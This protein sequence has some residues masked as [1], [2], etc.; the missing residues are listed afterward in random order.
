MANAGA[1]GPAVGEGLEI[2]TREVRLEAQKTDR[3]QQRET[4]MSS[5]LK[6]WETAKK[7]F[8]GKV[9]LALKSA[10]TGCPAETK[11]ELATLLKS[12]TGL[13][14][15]LRAVDLAFTLK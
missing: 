7:T 9:T 1:K 10:G 8:V 4:V 15:A 11:Q 3:D 14:P 13:T 6:D 12:E 2:H 5:F